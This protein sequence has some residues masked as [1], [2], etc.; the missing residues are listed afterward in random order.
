MPVLNQGA[1]MKRPAIT[2]AAAMLLTATTA[3]AQTPLQ[4]PARSVPVPTDVSPQMQAI[5]GRPINPNWR[6]IPQ[7]PEQ[8]AARQA[9]TGAAVDQLPAMRA[10]L[11][12][13][14]EPAIMGGVKVFVVTPERIAPRNRG[15]LLIQIHGGCYVVNPGQAAT[16]EAI[17]MA[18]IGHYKVIS[19]DYRMPPAAYFPAALDDVISVWQA[20]LK[21]HPARRMGVLGSSAGGALTLE[22]VL[23]AR[24]LGLPLPAAI[25][26]GTP[27]ADLT[28][29][30]DSFNTNAM[31][32]NVL[33]SREGFC[34]P[35]A[36]F[37][38]NGHDLAD[39]LLSPINGDMHG[40]PPA[41]LTTGTRDLLLSNTVRTHRKLRQAG[42]E[43]QLQVY[44]GQSHAQ[45]GRDDQAP[46]TREA[47]GEIAAFFDKHLAK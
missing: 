27:M 47:F 19:I 14:V 4:V 3:L 1:R 13:K 37:Y 22:M 20:A 15:R 12:V 31:V 46:E 25:S 28:G 34:D 5:I 7:T 41:I 9:A 17:L 10:R 35:A 11:H 18:G 21:T 43:A 38:A 29:A 40:F 23:R 36:K 30:G 33:I 8:W 39:P 16:T 24:Q 44:E 2:A 26:P 45:Y 6:D 42:V 32:D